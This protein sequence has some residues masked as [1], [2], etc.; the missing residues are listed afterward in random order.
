MVI[1]CWSVKGG[2]GTT[3]VAAS[4]ALL[5][6]RSSSNGAVLADL[7]GDLP[8][9]LGMTEP[10]GPGLAE[11]LASEASA[12]ALERLEAPVADGLR[13][14][15]RGSSSVVAPAPVARL[16]ELG[17]AL[18]EYDRPV[19]IDAGVVGDGSSA[20]DL[21]AG[22]AVSL[23]VLRPCYLALRR[24]VRAPLRPS[25][26]VLVQEAGRA[27]GKRDVE[28]VLGVPVRA[29]VDLDPAVARAVDAGLLACRLP[30][31]LERRLRR[32]A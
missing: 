17:V 28:E 10:Q 9:V 20:L 24:A 26:V 7:A 18:A 21:V 8:A 27:I 2:S 3:V 25:G 13:L 32:A 6:A 23:L 4:L 12:G 16:A 5:L 14:L 30:R 22:A 19:V 15:P 1:A 31:G 29:V 11:W